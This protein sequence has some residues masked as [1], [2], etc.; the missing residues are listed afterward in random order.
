[1]KK[2][3]WILIFLNA[4]LSRGFSY[5]PVTWISPRMD[6]LGGGHA[7]SGGRF[8]ERFYNPAFLAW[9]DSAVQYMD[10]TAALS[11]Q[12]P[13]II[14]ALKGENYTGMVPVD[15]GT[16]VK[17]SLIGPLNTGL[18]RDRFGFRVYNSLDAYTFIPNITVESDLG[19]RDDLVMQAGY[20]IPLPLP[21]RWNGRAAL[22]VQFKSFISWRY[23]YEKDILGLAYSLTDPSVLLNKPF[24]VKS[25]AGLDLGLA[26][27]WPGAWSAGLTLHDVFTPYA[28]LQYGSMDDYGAGRGYDSVEFALMPVVVSTGV[29]WQPRWDYPAWIGPWSVMMDYNDIFDF[30]YDHRENPLLK[31]GVGTELSFF[32]ILDFRMGLKDGLLSTGLGVNFRWFKAGISL[33]GEE[34]SSEPG[35]FSIYNIKLNIEISQ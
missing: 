24:T 2:I 23:L 6:A 28:D 5:T 30:L 31:I 22:G 4:S 27:Q 19:F 26:Y 11:G 33:Y 10:L 25:G 18:I 3:L 21:A 17:L 1:M 15:E 20:G 34:L 7:A 14:D 32:K 29:K 12:I 35:V 8:S 9:G 13:E 16:Y